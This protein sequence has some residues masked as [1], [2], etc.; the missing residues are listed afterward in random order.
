MISPRPSTLLYFAVFC[1]TI[2][3][4]SST[5]LAGEDWKPIDP[6][7][8]A[9]KTP[10]VEKDAD[11]EAIFWE[12]RVDDGATDELVF[13][14]YVRVKVFNDRGKESQSRIDLTYFGS[15]KI[16][17]VAARTIKPD[18][19]IVELKKEDVFERTIVK[20]SGAKL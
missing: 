13:T 11:A 5:A 17:D 1:L 9:S 16:K 19:T 3:L 8:L 15:S 4:F 18:G 10:V 6:A 12:V 2:G 14:H 7:D 20:A